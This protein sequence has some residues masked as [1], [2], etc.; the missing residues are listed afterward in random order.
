MTE[1]ASAPATPTPA[2]ATPIAGKLAGGFIIPE[3][4]MDA[5]AVMAAIPQR[6]PMLLID[7]VIEVTDGRL[8]AIKAVSALDPWFQGH[9]PH[10]PLMPGVL[11]IEA[12]AQAGA[13][14]G[15]FHES[16]VGKLLVLAGVDGARFRRP[17]TPGDTLRI[18]VTETHRRPSIG[19]IDARITVDGQVACEA[20]ITFGVTAG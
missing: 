17:V 16:R 15:S 6:Y 14:L 9:F 5:L 4:P 8:V 19:K 3:L 13:I 7:R 11:M 2:P 20:T 1:P 12:M 10:R 18:E